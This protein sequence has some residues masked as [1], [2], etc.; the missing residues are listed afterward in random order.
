MSVSCPLT[1]L[2]LMDFAEAVNINGDVRNMRNN[3]VKFIFTQFFFTKQSKDGDWVR[4]FKT[5]LIKVQSMN[6]VES[7][8]ECILI[9]FVSDD[10][11]IKT[12]TV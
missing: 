8:Y 7:I 6:L 5:I 2:L 10:N 9:R 3:A 4:E 1:I 12:D 11:A